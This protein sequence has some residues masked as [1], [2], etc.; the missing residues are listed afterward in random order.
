MGRTKVPTRQLARKYLDAAYDEATAAARQSRPSRADVDRVA[1]A[2][3]RG[4]DIAYAVS[5]QGRGVR[6]MQ[7]LLSDYAVCLAELVHATEPGESR[8]MRLD[9]AAVTLG[10][11]VVGFG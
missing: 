4:V 9:R 7:E 6:D 10:D 11:M 5:W 1:G 2:V 8:R 3:A